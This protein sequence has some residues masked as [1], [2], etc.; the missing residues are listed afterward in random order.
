[1]E[2]TPLQLITAD[3]LGLISPIVILALTGMAVL[4]AD[5]FVAGSNRIARPAT[6]FAGT[7]LAL[8]A[9]HGAGP[10]GSSP[11][12]AFYHCLRSDRIVFIAHNVILG[13]TLALLMVTPLYLRG[14]RIASGEFYALMVFSAMA[15]LAMAASNEL[16]TLFLNL[17]LL[18]FTLYILT[19]MEKDN[20]RSTEAAFKYFLVG[21]YAGAFLLFGLVMVFGALGT[22]HYNEMREALALEGTQGVLKSPLFLVAGF[23]LMLVGFGFKLTLAPFHMYAPDVYAGGPTP[24]IGAVATGSKIAALTAFYQ[25]FRIFSEWNERP[26]AIYLILYG[27]TVLSIAVGNIGALIQPNIKRLLAYSGVAHMGY[28]MIPLVAA[29]HSPRLMADAEMALAYYLVAY[30]LMTVLAFGVAATLGAR[31][32]GPL[33]RYAGLARNAPLLAAAMAVALLSLTGVP[34]TVGFFGKLRL[35]SVAIDAELYLLAIFGV[36]ASVVSAYYY[37]RVIV[38]MYMEE[39]PQTTA[40]AVSIDGLNVLALGL[41]TAGVFLFAVYPAWAL[42]Y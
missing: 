5:L 38:K 6:A 4:V 28:A 37:L 22:T 2:P 29:L 15:M 20:L 36:L 11:A 41:C 14:R 17:E 10:P 35:F 8:I 7:A 31:G 13:V 32:D 26:V 1:L 16:L 27:L 21:S 25:V 19:G 3:D 40:A 33:E 39:A 42:I 12:Y 23:S 24:V 30:G 18:S 9:L 34:P